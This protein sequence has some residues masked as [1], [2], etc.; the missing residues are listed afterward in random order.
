MK[1][2]V[3]KYRILVTSVLILLCTAIHQ[4]LDAGFHVTSLKKEIRECKNAK[5]SSFTDDNFIV[6]VLL[7]FTSSYEK[8]QPLF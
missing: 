6:K 1:K 5:K 3:N 8:A 2:P 4:N 7:R